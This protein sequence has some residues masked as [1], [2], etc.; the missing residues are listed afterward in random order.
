[1]WRGISELRD[2]LHNITLTPIQP[3]PVGGRLPSAPP[4][5]GEDTGGVNRARS[6][7][8]Q[9]RSRR[10]RSSE[11]LE[12]Q[13]PTPSWPSCASWCNGIE[14]MIHQFRKPRRPA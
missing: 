5:D 4:L 12:N 10:A 7:H 2:F 9:R 8:F 6:T 14:L 3:S 1:A 11:I 13:F